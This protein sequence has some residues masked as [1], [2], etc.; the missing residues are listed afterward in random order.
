LCIKDLHSKNHVYVNREEQPISASVLR[1][2]DVVRCGQSEF[3]VEQ[4]DE[5][6]TADQV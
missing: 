6:E 3:V 1:R 2:G 4:A 5:T